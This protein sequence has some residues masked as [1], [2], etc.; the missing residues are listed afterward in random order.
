MNIFRVGRLNSERLASIAIA[1]V[2]AYG[3]LKGFVIGLVVPS[4]EVPWM[5]GVSILL[6][7]TVHGSLFS[8]WMLFLIRGGTLI[9]RN[10]WSWWVPAGA[11]ILLAGFF[12]PIVTDV[13]LR[14]PD[15][16][17]LTHLFEVFR[18]MSETVPYS[19]GYGLALIFFRLEDEWGLMLFHLPLALFWTMN[20]QTVSL[21]H[22]L[23]LFTIPAETI[24]PFGPGE[25]IVMTAFGMPYWIYPYCLFDAWWWADAGV[26]YLLPLLTYSSL[27]RNRARIRKHLKPS[28]RYLRSADR[29]DP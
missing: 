27:L 10:R 19:L 28:S 23:G 21:L 3:F 22:Q 25:R 18:H 8:G 17:Y 1:A 26:G 4:L 15:P 16:E 7:L 5:R 2:I 12:S 14:D 9:R 13:F 20:A 6:N 11:V 24:P 29:R